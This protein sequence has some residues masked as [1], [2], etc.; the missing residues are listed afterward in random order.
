MATAA[1]LSL[2][3]ALIPW[4][5][6][7]WLVMGELFLAMFCASGFIILSIAYATDVY[8]PRY[9]GLISGLGSGAWSATVAV[10]MPLFGRLFDLE[11]YEAAFG[12]AAA[13]PAL[14]YAFWCWVNRGKPA[15]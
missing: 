8:S 4:L 7:L 3:L 10:M 12:L 2:P 15:L 13:F 9:A 11:S 1:L 6:S 5:P 14:G